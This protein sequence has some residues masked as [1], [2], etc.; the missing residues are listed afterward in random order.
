MGVNMEDF[1]TR[2]ELVKQSILKEIFLIS[3]FT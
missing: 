3:S 2:E 1:R